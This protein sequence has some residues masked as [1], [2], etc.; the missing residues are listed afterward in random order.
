MSNTGSPTP[1]RPGL[2]KWG[3]DRP[4]TSSGHTGHSKPWTDLSGVTFT[5]PTAPCPAKPRAPHTSMWATALSSIPK[6]LVEHI[7]HKVLLFIAGQAQQLGPQL[8]AGPLSLDPGLLVLQPLR[9]EHLQGWSPSCPS[10]PPPHWTP[11]LPGPEWG[12][13][14]GCTGQGVEASE[15]SPAHQRGRETGAGASQRRS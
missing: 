7:G 12:G 9:A 4:G 2:L 3:Q 6:D 15:D 13:G 14:W 1:A 5:L 10:G 8:L 11:A